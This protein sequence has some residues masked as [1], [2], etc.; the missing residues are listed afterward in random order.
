MYGFIGIEV[1]GYIIKI[2]KKLNFKRGVGITIKSK[3]TSGKLAIYNSYENPDYPLY[4]PHWL[5]FV[6]FCACS[7][8]HNSSWLANYTHACT[9]ETHTIAN[10]QDFI[11]TLAAIVRYR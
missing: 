4:K 2:N 10:L 1:L 11:P 7:C 9:N 8:K 3:E 6:A 5:L